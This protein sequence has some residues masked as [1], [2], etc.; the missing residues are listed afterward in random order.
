MQGEKLSERLNEI[1]ENNAGHFC[2]IEESAVLTFYY[3][4]WSEILTFSLYIWPKSFM[5]F[6][7]VYEFISQYWE[8]LGLF[9]LLKWSFFY[10]HI[11]SK[12]QGL[13]IISEK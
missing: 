3:Q 10:Y 9:I 12:E 5:N 4:L 6:Q 13:Y 11:C 7:T 8:H 1:G 2:V